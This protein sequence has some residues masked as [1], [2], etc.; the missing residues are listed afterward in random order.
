MLVVNNNG[1]HGGK[2]Q[3][4]EITLAAGHHT[5]EVVYFYTTGLVRTGIG[6]SSLKALYEGPGIDR[7]AIPPSKLATGLPKE[8][9]EDNHPVQEAAGAASMLATADVTALGSNELGKQEKVDELLME[10]PA[11]SIVV[12]V[13]LKIPK[14]SDIN[15]L[16]MA[17]AKDTLGKHFQRITE[18]TNSYPSI[19]SFRS[20][21]K[22]LQPPQFIEEAVEDVAVHPR[23]QAQQHVVNIVT[24]QAQY[25]QTINSLSAAK[26][27][28]AEADEQCKAEMSPPPPPPLQK[29]APQGEK[30]LQNDNG[31]LSLKH[32]ACPVGS[33]CMFRVKHYLQGGTDYQIGGRPAGTGHSQN[34]DATYIV[35]LENLGG[36][37]DG[38]LMMMDVRHQC[39]I[40]QHKAEDGVK[41]AQ[42]VLRRHLTGRCR[43]THCPPSVL[44][45][46]G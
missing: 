41:N 44:H 19:V 21:V 22:S 10:L 32:H 18:A 45:A 11:E 37:S 5:L 6:G 7:Q 27:T 2:T 24:K 15:K 3:K 29:A 39:G 36:T 4:G 30:L 12:T 40:T 20:S 38:N 17:L 42:D 8:K 13:Q 23:V 46:D 31:S 35:E 26:A 25:H 14:E 28:M 16:D 33:A 43:R 1:I 9:S 34:V